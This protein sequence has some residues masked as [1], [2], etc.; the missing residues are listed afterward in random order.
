MNS[1]FN[2]VEIVHRH[3]EFLEKLLR[4]ELNIPN[5][6]TLEMGKLIRAAREE[7]ELSQT[8]LAEKLSKRQATISDFE[9]GKIEIGILTLVH[10]AIVLGK[11]ISYFIPEMTFL[12]SLSDIH[13]KWEEEALSLYRDL[14]FQGDPEL[15]RRFM[16]M[17]LEYNIEQQD[18][19][20]GIPDEE[21]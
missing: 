12:V 14:E 1:I 13:N 11:P 18:P 9:N 2:D 21:D 10:L 17:L 8:E 19:M 7:K 16:K 6:F 20:W 3:E 5:E 4:N 15:A